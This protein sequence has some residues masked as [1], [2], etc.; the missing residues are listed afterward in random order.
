MTT[1]GNHILTARMSRLEG[2]GAFDVLT[3][4]RALEAEGHDVVHLEV[5][6]PDFDTPPHVREAGL[7][8]LRDGETR[9]GPAAGLADLRA[10][11]ARTATARGSA[12]TADNV[13]VT[14]GAKPMLFYAALATIQSGDEV[15]V[16]DPGFPIYASA[17]KFAGGDAVSYSLNAGARFSLDAGA[18]AARITPRTRAIVLNAPHNPT[19]GGVD[20]ATLERIAELALRH[21]LT[22]ITDEVYDHCVYDDASLPSISSF[23]E[24]RDRVIVINSFSKT[25]AMTGWRLGFGIVPTQTIERFVTLAV[26]GHSCVPAFVQRAG[27]AALNGPLDAV[28]AMVQEFRA[29]RDWLVPELSSIP[30]VT[31]ATPAGAFY[32]FPGVH[33]ILNATGTST[34]AFASRLLDRHGVAALAGTAFGIGGTGHI[35]LSFVASRS[36][37]ARAAA[38]LRAC[39]EELTH[40]KERSS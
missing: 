16:P 18:I 23:P 19:G 20:L 24:V 31:C 30:G 7:R 39:V 32:V 5:G 17:V 33:R 15:L 34:E 6:E 13:I 29:R 21:N 25:Y 11:V 9:Y 4:A 38:G 27:I 40:E 8:A 36:V 10:A 35:R 14:A 3:R 28:S 22:I 1:A 26:N 37:L 2:E 12:V